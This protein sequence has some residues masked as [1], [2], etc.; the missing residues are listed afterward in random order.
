[1]YF[2]DHNSE[3]YEY[4]ETENT[5]RCTVISY[6]EE[7][8]N[9]LFEEEELDYKIEEITKK[10]KDIECLITFE[11]ALSGNEVETFDFYKDEE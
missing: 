11:H 4:I 9:E 8:Y 10:Y 5:F 2:T 3:G 6:E 7:L 1:M